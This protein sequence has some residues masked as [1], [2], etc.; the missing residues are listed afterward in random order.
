M[1]VIGLVV[2]RDEW[3]SIF[4]YVFYYWEG[5]LFIGLVFLLGGKCFELVGVWFFFVV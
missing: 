1:G 3:V 2:V 5:F 4:C